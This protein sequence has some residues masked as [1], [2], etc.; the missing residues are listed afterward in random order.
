[1]KTSLRSKLWL[2]ALLLLLPFAG[3][4]AEVAAGKVFQI[5]N[6][7]Y[8]LAVTSNG[9]DGGVTCTGPDATKFAQLWIAEDGDSR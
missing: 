1:M 6:D 8:G 5:V 9:P 2:A 3:R 7:Q 4:A